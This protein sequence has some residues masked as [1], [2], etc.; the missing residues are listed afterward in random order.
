MG[1][2]RNDDQQQDPTVA[3]NPMEALIE[4]IEEENAADADGDDLGAGV[5]DSSDDDSE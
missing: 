2:P 5:D 4:A 3:E 1:K